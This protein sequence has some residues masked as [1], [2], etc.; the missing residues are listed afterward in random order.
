VRRLIFLSLHDL[1]LN[2][3]GEL[4]LPALARSGWAIDVVGVHATDSM[5]GRVLPFP[6]RRHDLPPLDSRRLGL[7]WRVLGWLQRARTGPFDAIYIHSNLLAPRAALGLAGP[8]FGKRLVY[9]AHDYFDPI[10]H[11]VHAWLEGRLTRKARYY[12]NGEFHRAYI[13]QTRYGFRAPVLIVPPHLPSA[14]PIPEPSPEIRRKLGAKSCQDVIVMH[15]GGWSPLRATS[16]LFE[17][18]ATLPSRFRLVMTTNLSP[19]LLAEMARLGIEQRVACIG[20]QRYEDLFQYT[21]SSDIGVLLYANNDLGNF[22][23]APGRLTEYLASG[24]PVLTTHFTGLQLLTLKHGIGLSADPGSPRDIADRLLELEAG[25]RDGRF[26]RDAIRQHFLDAFAFDHWEDA[27]CRAFEE[28]LDSRPL[29]AHPI[30]P[31][32]SAIGGPLYVPERPS[33]LQKRLCRLA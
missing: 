21:S 22:F 12:L 13:D 3:F 31:S 16:Q 9:H 20:R 19:P 27:V 4:A 24:I 32:L 17:A 14:W 30:R 29:P 33:E 23:Q 11:P 8:L 15:H 2:P 1:G 7:E 18:L 6:C 25:R 26:S 5:L 28:V 10:D